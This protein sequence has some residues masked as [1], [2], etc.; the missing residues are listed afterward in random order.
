[1]E[2]ERIK[3]L[4]DEID[5]LTQIEMAMKQRFAP[6]GHPF[7]DNTT[8]LPDYFNKRFKDLGGMTPEISKQIGW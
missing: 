3:Q 5:E 6:A 8:K 7:F 1:M 4:Q 2:N